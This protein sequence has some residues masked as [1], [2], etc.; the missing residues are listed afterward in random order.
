MSMKK[1]VNA[2]VGT[3]WG[4]EAKGAEIDRQISRAC[5]SPSDESSDQRSVNVVVR[6]NGAHNAGHTVSL[7]GRLGG[8]LFTSC[9]LVHFTKMSRMS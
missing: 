3:A 2:V 1:N 9:R 5:E 8:Y 6:A 4:D 7:A